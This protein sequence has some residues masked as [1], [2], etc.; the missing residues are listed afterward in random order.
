MSRLFV[1]HVFQLA[2]NSTHY[3]LQAYASLLRYTATP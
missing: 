1:A 3:S 2:Y